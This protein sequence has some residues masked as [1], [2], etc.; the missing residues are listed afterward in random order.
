MKI[1][2]SLTA[3]KPPYAN[4][5]RKLGRWDVSVAF[6]HAKMDKEKIAVNP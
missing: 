1:V 6:F 3:S 5:K 4:R 2:I